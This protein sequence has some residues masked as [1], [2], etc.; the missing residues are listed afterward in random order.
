MRTEQE[1]EHAIERY[2]S[3][4]KGLRASGLE[5]HAM[6]ADQAVAALKWVKGEPSKFADIL[7]NIDAQVNA[8]FAHN[9]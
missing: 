5:A 2:T 1:I 3:V 4:C 9:N 6:I 8:A 7:D